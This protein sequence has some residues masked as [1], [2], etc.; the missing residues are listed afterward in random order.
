MKIPG[1]FNFPIIGAAY[2]L[3]GG[4]KECLNVMLKLTTQYPP[5][6]KMWIGP[7]LYVSTTRPEDIEVILPNVLNK[8]EIY[9]LAKDYFNGSLLIAPLNIWKEHRK[10]IN[11]TFNTNVLKSFVPIL[12][13]YA[14]ILSDNLNSSEPKDIFPVL[15]KFTFESACETLGDV[16]ANLLNEKDTFLSGIFRFEDLLTERFFNPFLQS[17]FFW[18]YSALKKE[19][20]IIS[21]KARDF[22]E[23]IIR[24]NRCSKSNISQ[25]TQDVEYESVKKKRFINYLLELHDTKKLTHEEILQE[26]PLMLFASSETTAIAVSSVLLVLGLHHDIQEKVFEEITSILGNSDRNFTTEDINSMDYLERVIK[27]TMRIIAPIPFI[28][29]TLDRDVALDTYVIPAGTRMF[30][31]ITTLHRR[32]DL[33]PDPFKFDPD[34]FLP[35]EVQKRNRFTYIPFSCG[36]RNCIGSKYAMLSMKIILATIVK[37]YKILETVDY[38]NIEDIEF[39]FFLVSKA[40]K[41]YR[42]LFEKRNEQKSS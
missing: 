4:R 32:A 42:V 13:K 3:L 16:D 37:N 14:N 38:K 17:D 27:E 5:I 21:K 20:T 35:E 28:L 34:R 1:P 24:I 29:R 7:D 40:K 30:F 25:Q 12:T 31:P 6:F 19:A 9:D 15:W 36:A 33:W 2:L 23:Q 10:I 22:V 26:T 18:K 8:G 11:Q 39:Y 41:G